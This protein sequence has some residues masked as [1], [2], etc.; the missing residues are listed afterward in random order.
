MHVK[1]LAR[2]S[3]DAFRGLGS[4]DV[5]CIVGYRYA[6]VSAALGADNLYVR[7]A[8]A[9][10]GT[11]FAV[12]E[13]FSISD[14]EEYNPPL[15]IC[16]GDRAV[17]AS[18]F[19][20]LQETHGSGDDEAD[21]TLLTAEY[22]P[23]AH[24]GKGRILRDAAGKVQRI[25]EE[26][27]IFNHPPGPHQDALLAMTEGNCPLYM[28]RAR[29]LLRYLGDLS[30]A[31][32]QGQYYLTD[33]VE[34]IV[35]DGGEIPHGNHAALGAGIRIA[36]FG[37]P[38]SR[39]DITR[40]KQM[41]TTI[42]DL[43]TPDEQEAESLALAIAA[44]RPEGQVSSIASQLEELAHMVQRE[45]LG[46]DPDR[47]VGIGISGGRLRL[48]FM[49]PDMVRFYGPAWQMPIGAVDQDGDEQIVM[50]VQPSDDGRMHLYPLDRI[51]RENRDDVDV[52]M[53]CMYPGT[54]ITDV[55]C[56]RGVRHQTQPRGPY[57]HSATS[58]KK[59]S[60]GAATPSFRFPLPRGGSR[61]VCDGR[62][63]W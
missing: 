51:Y 22:V 17:P 53:D 4:K 25:V 45:R 18:T 50:L 1:P 12:F 14:L 21:L 28:I 34:A 32:A 52:D 41:L 42:T 27:D 57:W 11:A 9:T 37:R 3:I 62:F 15:V 39:R 26:R 46:L 33:I 60:P 29:T 38:P 54:A 7:S 10:G 8:N 20:Q 59:N 40:L 61:R 56:V 2:Y 5:V 63:R 58:T 49:H 31:N 47:P 44:H 35:R 13:A 16:M 24:R 19:R 30:N 43:S 23:P 55:H 6:E 48:A 36:L